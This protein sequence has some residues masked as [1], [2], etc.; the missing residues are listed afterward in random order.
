M[1]IIINK[2]KKFLKIKLLNK[3]KKVKKIVDNYSH[4]KNKKILMK[5]VVPMNRE[6]KRKN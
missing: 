4:K 5:I 6:K 2:E 1:K 3:K